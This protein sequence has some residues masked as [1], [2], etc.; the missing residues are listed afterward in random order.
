MVGARADHAEGDPPDGDADDEVAV[1][2]RAPP[3]HA[4]QPDAGEDRD[5]QRQP[6]EVDRE[7]PEM[8]TPLEGEGMNRAG[9]APRC[10]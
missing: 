1:A 5:Q 4:G 6:V 10:S 8:D 9:C 3:A 2:A 7:R